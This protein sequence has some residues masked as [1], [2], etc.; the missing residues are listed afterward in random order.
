M[1]HATTAP[2]PRPPR[3]G[4][5]LK[6]SA[7][8]LLSPRPNSQSIKSVAGFFSKSLQKMITHSTKGRL[9]GD[10]TPTSPLSSGSP[11]S[12]YSPKPSESGVESPPV[13]QPIGIQPF[14]AAEA[15]K[16]VLEEPLKAVEQSVQ[17]FASGLVKWAA[18]TGLI[19]TEA[20]AAAA[21]KEEEVEE[22][23]EEE[24][25]PAIV[26]LGIT[27]HG[28]PWRGSYART[29]KIGEGR[30]MTFDPETERETNTWTSPFDVPKA[31]ISAEE[32]ELL[33]A[34]WPRAPDWLLQKFKF[35]LNDA[36]ADRAALIAALERDGIVV[37]HAL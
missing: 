18:D 9:T 3:R 10:V 13:P 1:E 35:S 15:S 26:Q 11:N 20:E 22:V 23:E 37:D 32:I 31:T 8:K 24:V 36:A 14:Q 6:K 28:V 16:N 17:D 27:K 19:P 29:L 30:V 33:V 2:P 7:S 5:S 34:P 25:L 4:S 21:P 12:N